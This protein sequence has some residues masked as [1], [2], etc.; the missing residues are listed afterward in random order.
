M[1]SVKLILLIVDTASY[2]LDVHALTMVGCVGFKHYCCYPVHGLP[3][4]FCV[5]ITEIKSFI[6]LVHV[7]GL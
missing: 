2:T 6:R 1:Y 5:Q 7:L 3:T 4:E